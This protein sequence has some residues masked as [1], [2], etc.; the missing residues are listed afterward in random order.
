MLAWAERSLAVLKESRD[1]FRRK[2]PYGLWH[3]KNGETGEYTLHISVAEAIESPPEWVFMI[4][5][6]IHNMRVSLDYAA[7]AIATKCK[8]G[9]TKREAREVAFPICRTEEDFHGAKRGALKCFSQEAVSVIERLQPY[10]T[11]YRNYSNPLLIL[12]RLDKP[13]KHRNLLAAAPNVTVINFFDYTPQSGIEIISMGLEG[14][15]KDGAVVAR[16]RAA[17]LYDATQPRVPVNAEVTMEMAFLDAGPA[18]REPAIP[19]L[20]ESAKFIGKFVFPA[21]EPYV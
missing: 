8:P 17:P 2:R 14:D 13:H 16:A 15:F 19:F 21:L 4:G 1:A 7:F 5:D 9:M 10:H 20:E 6:I 3:D 18:P 11:T 12:H